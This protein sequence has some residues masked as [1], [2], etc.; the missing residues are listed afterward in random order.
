MCSKKN[1]GDHAGLGSGYSLNPCNLQ[2][3]RACLFHRFTLHFAGTRSPALKFIDQKAQ[4]F[5]VFFFFMVQ[6]HVLK[7]LLD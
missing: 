7:M 2:L 3:P 6:A 1:I 4:L 5:Y